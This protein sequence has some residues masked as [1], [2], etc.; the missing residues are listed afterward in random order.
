MLIAGMMTGLVGGCGAKGADQTEG[1]ETAAEGAT[2][3]AAKTLPS[4]QIGETFT[5]NINGTDVSFIMMDLDRA[6]VEMPVPSS[7]IDP[8]RYRGGVA[9][10]DDWDNYIICEPEDSEYQYYDASGYFFYVA[11]YAVGEK[12][13]VYTNEDGTSNITDS[14]TLSDAQLKWGGNNDAFSLTTEPV[15]TDRDNGTLSVSFDTPL[16]KTATINGVA[17]QHTW[18]GEYYALLNGKQELNLI[19][20]NATLDAATVKAIGDYMVDNMRFKEKTAMA[21][22][23]E[24]YKTD[25]TAMH[26]NGTDVT[27]SYVDVDGMTFL[28][29]NLYFTFD[30][31]NNL[32]QADNQSLYRNDRA[33]IYAKTGLSGISK[34]ALATITDMDSCSSILGQ[35][36]L[37]NYTGDNF[38]MTTKGD[39]TYL[40]F[41]GVFSVDGIDYQTRFNIMTN[42]VSTYVFVIGCKPDGGDLAELRNTIADSCCIKNPQQ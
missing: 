30:Y 5:E 36:G 22:G 16:N 1:T 40:T 24:E 23:N 29:D 35:M 32:M 8:T 18:Q 9:T 17:E 27:L 14:V 3:E 12:G 31:G 37:Y 15:I 26:A 28:N 21:A 34:E 33:F 38:A 19:F 25:L 10:E 2:E 6:G 42:S 7:L 11:G 13:C 39:Y 20:G 41:E 4:H